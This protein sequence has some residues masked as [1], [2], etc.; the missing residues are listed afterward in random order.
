MMLR[1]FYFEIEDPDEDIV[2]EEGCLLEKGLRKFGVC[3]EERHLPIVQMGLF[4]D[5]NGIPI[6]IE[7]FPG[8]P[9]I[10]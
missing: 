6:A 3:K 5:D 10:T 8:K 2:D 9:W 7:S 1:N 4:M